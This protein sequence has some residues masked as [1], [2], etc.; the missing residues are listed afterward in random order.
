[1]TLKY[2]F[3]ELD[4]ELLLGRPQQLSGLAEARQFAEKLCRTPSGCCEIYVRSD[5]GL[6]FYKKLEKTRNKSA[7]RAVLDAELRRKL[8]GHCGILSVSNVS[9]D[10]YGRRVVISFVMKTIYG[11]TREEY[12]W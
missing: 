12:E 5:Y 11:D 4:T 8:P 6:E 1:M 10:I 2:D 9:L 7:L 3:K